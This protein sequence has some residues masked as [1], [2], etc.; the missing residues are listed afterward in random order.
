MRARGPFQRVERTFAPNAAVLSVIASVDHERASTDSAAIAT[1][2][3]VP[4]KPAAV[5]VIARAR[6]EKCT[7]RTLA[8][9]L[10]AIRRL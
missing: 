7:N 5:A 1:T 4:A 8:P 3:T 10:C 9:G 6:E 2:M